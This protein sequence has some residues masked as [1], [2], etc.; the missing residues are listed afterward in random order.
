MLAISVVGTG[1]VGLSTAVC[2]AARG[3]NVIA[4]T[5]DA[6]KIRLINDKIPPFYEPL[7]TEL[8]TRSIESGNLKVIYGREEAI[9]N[10]DVTFVTVGTPELV[11][12]GI[13]LTFVK[14]ACEE[15]GRALRKKHEYHLVAIKSTVTPGTTNGLA[16]PILE[17]GSGKSA[18]SD[19]GLCM[20][21]EFLRQGSSIYDMFN[22]DRV[23]IG[24][25]DESSGDALYSLF[26]EF[27]HNNVPIVR[28]NLAS[29]EMVKYASNAFLATKISFANEVANVC[30]KLDDIDVNHVM[31]GVGLDD[32]INPKF[33]NA[34]A[35]FGGSCLPKD[36]K[37]LVSMAK[38]LSYEAPLLRSVLA[39]N[40]AQALHIADLALSILNKPKGK[41]VALL[42]LSFKPDTDDI[43][44]A[45]SLKIARRLIDNGAVVCAFDPVVT[46][47]TRPNF[48]DLTC[49]SSVEECLR[50]ARCCI[51]VTEWDQFKHLEPEDFIKNMSEPV[52][53]D[54]RRVYD[55]EKFVHKLH[56]F[57]VGL[58]L[59]RETKIS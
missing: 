12:G 44:E 35:G 18:G 14:K 21:P 16:K 25:Y 43:R 53:I 48:E 6:G 2:F 3:Y 13:D 20:T 24:E 57:G 59:G 54:A 7:L 5:Y 28:M 10:T 29:A 8:L 47:I 11:D 56:F 40:E 30:E 15:I 38:A 50:G 51:L 42:G 1:Y 19:F 9:L 55:A 41:K 49:A 23:I 4:S 17:A 58:P 45:P 31:A 34:G 22:P 37:A 33:L 39:V 52:L 26:Q 36:V 46:H 27:Y 32:R